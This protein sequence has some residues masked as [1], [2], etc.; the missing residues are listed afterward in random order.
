[1]NDERLEEALRVSLRRQA[2]PA[3][4]AARVLEKTAI[5]LPSPKPRVAVMRRPFTLA[6]AAALAAVAIV[7]A[8]LVERQRTEAA[9][10]LK[11]KRELLTALAIAG[12]QLRQARA[13]VQ[14]NTRDIQ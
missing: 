12:D 8:V 13:R 6:L 1:M 5:P 9:K 10:G 3:G 4:F 11:A 2:A 14:K 7:P